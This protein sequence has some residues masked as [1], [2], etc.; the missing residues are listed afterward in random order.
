MR[1]LILVVLGLTAA[2]VLIPTTA[3]ADSA[4]HTY[5]LFMESANLGLAPNGDQIAPVGTKS[6]QP[7]VSVLF[8]PFSSWRGYIEVG[9]QR[10]F[11]ERTW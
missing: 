5:T 7:F 4:T 6:G 11:L 9:F 8:R 3:V 1:R 2:L 10:T